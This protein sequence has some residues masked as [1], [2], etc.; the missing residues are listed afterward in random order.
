[1]CNKSEFDELG[2]DNPEAC[3]NCGHRV[4]EESSCANCGAILFN[5][6]DLNPFEEDESEMSEL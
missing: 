4:G 1:M 3:P 2:L 6:D 5:D